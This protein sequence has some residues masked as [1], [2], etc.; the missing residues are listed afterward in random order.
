MLEQT[1]AI[2]RIGSRQLSLNDPRPVTSLRDIRKCRLGER[3]SDI[4][5]MTAIES[6]VAFARTTAGGADSYRAAVP[7]S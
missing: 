5:A 3:S 2:D 6:A 7:K 4:R 1:T